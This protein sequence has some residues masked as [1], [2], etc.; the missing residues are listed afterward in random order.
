[1][2]SSHKSMD[3]KRSKQLSKNIPKA[4]ISGHNEQLSRLDKLLKL[5]RAD[6]PSKVRW[7]T[8]SLPRHQQS[9]FQLILSASYAGVR[10][11]KACEFVLHS[12]L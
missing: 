6:A 8:V 2:I 3:R 11:D 4:Q 12:S 5:L 7:Q 1:M 9:F 10:P